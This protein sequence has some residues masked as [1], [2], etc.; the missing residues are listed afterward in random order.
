V[1]A[2]LAVKFADVPLHTVSL[3]TVTTGI[4]LVVMVP[5][6]VEEHPF[7]VP[8][9]VYEVV[10]VGLAVNEL[11][12][13]PPDQRYVVAPP[14]FNVAG[15]PAHTIALV[16]V[17]TGTLLMV[18]VLVAVTSGQLPDAAMVLVTV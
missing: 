9:T 3:F 14:A 13:V 17:V 8:V 6:A 12:V 10:E 16:A 1:L 4:G 15:D 5:T 7:V 18:M 11:A 2:P